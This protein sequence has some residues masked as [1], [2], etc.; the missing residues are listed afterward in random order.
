[1][2]GEIRR[3]MLDTIDNAVLQ[4]VQDILPE[5]L[6]LDDASKDYFRQ[7]L[8]AK[9]IQTI[10][11]IQD[12]GLDFFQVASSTT[13]E[14]GYVSIFLLPLIALIQLIENGEGLSWSVRVNW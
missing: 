13:L 1:M 4:L 11:S 6:L 14:M 5:I 3:M 12:G 10:L 7:L 9:G 8:I 2:G